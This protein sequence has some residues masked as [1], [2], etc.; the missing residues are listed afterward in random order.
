MLQLRHLCK[1]TSKTCHRI[2]LCI[3]D[4]LFSII[5]VAHL[6]HPLP[7]SHFLH[8]WLPRQRGQGCK[9]LSQ[10]LLR[11]NPTDASPVIGFLSLLHFLFLLFFWP[12]TLFILSIS[13]SST[14][15]WDQPSK[16]DS[17]FFTDHECV[18]S[19]VTEAA[20]KREKRGELIC[21]SFLH[22]T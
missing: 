5:Y 19:Y 11:H 6:S 20:I 4:S 16:T 8:L 7:P 18:S 17:E 2:A 3:R 14:D 15:L 10:F 1:C 12:C 9:K 13:L 22:L 21:Q